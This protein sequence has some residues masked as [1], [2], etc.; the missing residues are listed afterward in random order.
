MAERAGFEPAIEFPLYTLSRRAPS[1]TR[2]PLRDA[3]DIRRKDQQVQ[4]ASTDTSVVSERFRTPDDSEGISTAR[5]CVFGSLDALHIVGLCAFLV[6]GR[7]ALA[8]Q[9]GYGFSSKTAH[10]FLRFVETGMSWIDEMLVAAALPVQVT[11]VRGAFPL[12][13]VV[14][15]PDDPSD[16]TQTESTCTARLGDTPRPSVADWTADVMDDATL[17]RGR[18]DQSPP[19]NHMIVWQ[20]GK[21]WLSMRM[22]VGLPDLADLGY[23]YT[24]GARDLCAETLALCNGTSPLLDVLPDGAERC[25]VRFDPIWF[26]RPQG[27]ALMERPSTADADR[28]LSGPGQIVLPRFGDGP[29]AIRLHRGAETTDLDVAG[30]ALP[31]IVDVPPGPAVTALEYDMSMPATLRA[32]VDADPMSALPNTAWR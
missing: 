20:R 15:R 14:R 5:K 10:C 1:T 16:W 2:P 8:W 24:V 13:G 7:V 32:S 26:W 30:R 4:P 3:A 18:S 11:G 19:D 27:A 22:S 23:R 31:A 25:R 17:V 28:I 21:R 29:H 12:L 6:D 9:G